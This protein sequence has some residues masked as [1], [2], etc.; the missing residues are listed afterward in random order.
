MIQLRSAHLIKITN[1]KLIRKSPIDNVKLSK[2]WILTGYIW[3]QDIY[4]L[5]LTAGVNLKLMEIQHYVHFTYHIHLTVKLLK[6]LQ[7]KVSGNIVP[8]EDDKSMTPYSWLQCL[9]GENTALR[10]LYTSVIPYSWLRSLNFTQKMTTEV[11]SHTPVN[12]R[13]HLTQIKKQN[14]TKDKELFMMIIL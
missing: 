14:K 9:I 13:K 1:I 11:F 2:S 8:C 3:E 10:Q 7:S 6:F 5:H 12:R 4:Q